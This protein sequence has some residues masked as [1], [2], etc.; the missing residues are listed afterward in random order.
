MNI[1][2][3]RS[4]IE[5]NYEVI[6]MEYDCK[7]PLG[8]HLE[9]YM[10]SDLSKICSELEIRGIQ[11]IGIYGLQTKYNSIIKFVYRKDRVPNMVCI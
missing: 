11:D 7:K 4:I 8:E 3:W 10:D 6:N 5:E 1:D 2:G 9:E